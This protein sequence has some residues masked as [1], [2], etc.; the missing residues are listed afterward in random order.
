MSIVRMHKIAI[1]GLENDKEDIIEEL[2]NIGV[3]HISDVS[4][5]LQDENWTELVNIEENEEEIFQLALDIEKIKASLD[6][7]KQY[8]KGKKALFAQK[9]TVDISKFN[10]IIENKDKIWEAVELINS[11]DENLNK[12]KQEKNK[13]EN[14][15]N[16]LSPWKSLDIPVQLTGTKAT[17]IFIGVIPAS[18]DVNSLKEQLKSEVEE[19]YI[20]I[21][22]EDRDQIYIVAICHKSRADELLN[23]LKNHG[24][25]KVVFK[26]MTGTVEQNIQNSK[27][28]ILKIEERI[29]SLIKSIDDLCNMREDIEML[30][31]YLVVEKDRKETLGR[32]LNTE[33]TFIIE[34]WVPETEIDYFK[35]S[36]GKWRWDCYIHISEPEEGEEYP[37]LLENNK[38]V[39]PFEVVT[40]MYSLPHAGEID[41]NAIMA[42]FF[43]MFFG[44]MVSDAGY[45][46]LLSLVSAIAIYK[47]KPKG[48]L[49]KL[50]KLLL[51]CGIS[52]IIWGALFGGWFGDI[53]TQ[54]TGGKV[55]IKPI[56]FNPLEDPMKLLIW[57]LIF[58]GIHLYAAMGMKAYDAIKKGRIWDAI[59]DTGF[60]YIFLTGLA[61]LL[62]GGKAGTIGKYMAI[63]GA[64][65]LILTQGRAEKNIIKKF[66]KGVGSLY[67]AVGFMSDVLSYSRLLALGLATGVIASVINTIGTLFGFNIIGVI[68]FIV[69]FFVG[70]IF[71]LLINALGAFVHTSRLQYVE[72]FGKFFEG[73]GKPYTPFK[74]NTKYVNIIK[75]NKEKGE[76]KS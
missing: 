24:F 75:N 74:I 16:S 25:N 3:L 1:I 29:T 65:L 40:E 30:Y 18:Y 58:G 71:N 62:V 52:T 67:N 6:Y 59:F 48:M 46:I 4:G 34:G 21:V 47:L 41:P 50:L 43:F 42:P 13:L 28:E 31:D 68:V 23:V 9:R 27:H 8:D 57:S 7:L 72:F 70:H 61:L 20:H 56:W 38:L 69:A 5:K 55:E 63:I 19:S 36:T 37:I 35:E 11:M 32:L 22:S 51:L 66:T 12:L 76:R 26:E 54:I 64:I 44:M 14:S 49:E 17:S 53:V 10:S 33:H 15:I 60:W 2:M 73:G 39:Q 45:G